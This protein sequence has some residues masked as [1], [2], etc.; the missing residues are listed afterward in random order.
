MGPSGHNWLKISV[1]KSNGPRSIHEQWLRSAM[2]NPSAGCTRG[3]EHSVPSEERALAEAD[4]NFPVF[5][6]NWL[7]L[8]GE[9]GKGRLMDLLK[10]GREKHRLSTPGSVLGSQFILGLAHFLIRSFS[11]F[12]VLF[13]LVNI[14]LS[15]SSI[16][17]VNGVWLSTSLIIYKLLSY[18]FGINIKSLRH[19]R[20]SHST[21]LLGITLRK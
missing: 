16:P 5:I 3:V 9:L 7:E 10:K 14:P 17:Q 6:L 12:C 15:L 21:L 4:S 1:L 18:T 8:G 11:Y 2:A 20:S 19:I 13:L